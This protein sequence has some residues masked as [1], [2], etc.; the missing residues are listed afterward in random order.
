M[1]EE[2]Y[3]KMLEDSNGL[4]AVCAEPMQRVCID[5]DHSTK[6]VRGLLCHPCNIKLHAIDTWAHLAQALV[7]LKKQQVTPCAS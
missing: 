5:H 1:T 2:T 6:A 7:Y 3:Q 4:C